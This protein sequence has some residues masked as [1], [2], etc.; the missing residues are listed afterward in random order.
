MIAQPK[1]QHRLAREDLTLLRPDKL[2]RHYHQA[3]QRIRE[4]FGKQPDLLAD[5]FA[6]HYRTPL[7][8][9]GITLHEQAPQPA[10]CQYRWR[11]TRLGFA[12]DRALLGELLERYYGGAPL[13]TA[14]PE[15]A[16]ASASEQRLRDRLG[17]Q[18]LGL[19]GRLLLGEPAMQ[20]LERYP[21]KDEGN[22]EFTVQLEVVNPVSGLRASLWLYLDEPMV[23]AIIRHAPRRSAGVVSPPAPVAIEALPVRLQCVLLRLPMPLAQVLALKPDDVLLVRLPERHAV[24]INSLNLFTASL[25][26]HAGALVLTSFDSVNRP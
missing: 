24:C 17:E 14:A 6:R 19:C 16:K 7:Q 3:G 2:G 8:W 4:A 22:W 10:A 9:Q 25:A 1:V 26:Q 11:D 21:G 23:D 12:A 15:E 5:H 20:R 13:P 18:L